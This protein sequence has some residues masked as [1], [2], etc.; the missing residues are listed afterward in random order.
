MRSPNVFEYVCVSKINQFSW[1]VTLCNLFCWFTGSHGY[2]PNSPWFYVGFFSGMKSKT[3]FY[4]FLLQPLQQWSPTQQSPSISSDV[5]PKKTFWESNTPCEPLILALVHQKCRLRSVVCIV[6]EIW[7][8]SM[9]DQSLIPDGVGFDGGICPSR[10]NFQSKQGSFGFQVYCS[11]APLRP[12]FLA[13]RIH[14]PKAIHLALRSDG[15]CYA[16]AVSSCE[17]AEDCDCLKGCWNPTTNTKKRGGPSSQVI[18][19]RH[20]DDV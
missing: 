9:K 2:F 8:I 16:A 19:L 6:R 10:S 14:C 1:K 15:M 13:P 17:K 12:V 20:V 3:E 5:S 11:I 4:L 7:R 18:I